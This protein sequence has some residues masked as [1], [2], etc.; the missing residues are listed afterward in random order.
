VKVKVCH[1]TSVHP[2]LDTRIFFKECKTL[3][4][5]G[6]DV[7]LIAKTD[8]K[9]P[10]RAET[11][12]INF[13]P[14]PLYKNRFKRVLFSPFKMAALA[15]AQ[16]AAIYHFHDPE[17]LIT[18]LL[19]R[20]FTRS[21]VIYDIHEDYAKNFMD[22]EW[23]KFKFLRRVTAKFFYYFELLVSRC[24]S[25]TIVVLPQWLTKYPNAV[26]VRNFPLP[27]NTADRKDKD[28][29]VYVGTLGSKRCALEMIRIF[30]ELS[31]LKPQ[32][33]FQMI[34]NFF[35]KSVETSVREYVNRYH[36]I[37]YLGYHPF[38]EARKILTRAKYGFVLYADIKYRENV[39]V[40]MY[41]YLAHGIVAIFSSFDEFKYEI[42][43]EG[44][45]IGVNPLKPREAA[46]KIHQI[47][48]DQERL[49]TLEENIQKHKGKYSWETEK[50]EL[51]DLYRRLAGNVT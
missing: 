13:V 29:F 35:E 28:L 17:L 6:Y 27:E 30:I 3:S 25:G 5:A 34:G 8:N 16:K 39:P 40:K 42:E 11:D 24:M 43:Q 45:G 21:R 37:E 20:L 51:L 10:G 14:F 31:Q 19:L 38:S 2:P 41:E 1:L 33:K 23:M 49:K 47:M 26:L 22:K 4:A 15:R 9:S 46:L 32:I 36:N 48:I 12:D 44:W 50:Q 7:T 18:G